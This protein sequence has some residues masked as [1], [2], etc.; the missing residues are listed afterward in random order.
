MDINRQTV[1]QWLKNER[2]NQTWLAEQCEVS[3]QAV[4]NWLREKNPQAISSAATIKIHELMEAD[5]AGS[6]PRPLQNLVLE[7]QDD[8][9]AAIGRAALA[10]NELI[11]VWAKRVLNEIVNENVADLAKRVQASDSILAFP[12]IPLLHAAAG[13]PAA[14]DSDTYSPTRA[15]GPGRFAC[16]L[17]GDSMAPRYPDGSTVILRERQS[18]N[19][20]IL[21]KGQ[22]YLFD[23]AGEKTLKV[24]ESRLATSDEIDDGLSYISENDGKTK[25]RVLRSLN[26]NFTDIVVKEPIDW[27]GWLDISDNR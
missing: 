11:P 16:Q 1:L 25:V 21:K 8:E 12:E 7:F 2:R 22:I 27:L 24:Y 4:S 18:L 23:T 14:T 15:L 9:F 20:P 6:R 13:S 5:A 19:R 17:H 10:T 26:R 3:K